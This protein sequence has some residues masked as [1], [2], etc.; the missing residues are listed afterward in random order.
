MAP[1]Q[2]RSRRGHSLPIE[3]ARHTAHANIDTLVAPYD[4]SLPHVCT[5]A[6]DPDLLDQVQVVCGVVPSDALRAE[7]VTL[8]PGPVTFLHT[9]PSQA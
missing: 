5:L 2:A 6:H 7:L 8:A 9:T 3:D 4:P 1:W